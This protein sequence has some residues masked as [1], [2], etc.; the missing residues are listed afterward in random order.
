MSAILQAIEEGLELT[1]DEARFASKVM[2]DEETG[3]WVWVGSRS[4]SG[5][6][7]IWMQ[8]RV[9]PAH[10]WLWVHVNGALSTD[11]Y[12]DH[13]C[14]NKPCVNPEHLEPVTP[15]ENTRRGNALAAA[16][17]SAEDVTHCPF[18][19]RYSVENTYI[20]PRG[21]RTCR[22][23]HRLDRL[24]GR[25]ERPGRLSRKERVACAS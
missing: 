3:C 14:C 10:R 15:G 20:T 9:Q 16:R 4:T 6:G 24:V 17:R 18:G 5:Y 11:L 8:G 13:L 2:A 25:R 12:L 1:L 22:A 21:A 7:Q 19:H 23:C